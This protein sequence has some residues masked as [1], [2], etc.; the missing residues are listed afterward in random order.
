MATRTTTDLKGTGELST[1]P[2]E[3]LLGDKRSKEFILG[4]SEALEELKGL[5][6]RSNSRRTRRKKTKS[7]RKKKKSKRKKKK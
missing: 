2:A 3:S 4:I 5:K 6:K 1:D 7:K